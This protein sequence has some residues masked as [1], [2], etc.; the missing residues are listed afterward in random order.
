MVTVN[1]VKALVD[2]KDYEK[3]YQKYFTGSYMTGRFLKSYC[4]IGNYDGLQDII[5]NCI[6]K[7]HNSASVLKCITHINKI[8]EEVLIDKHK[9]LTML[10]FVYGQE[11]KNNK[12]V[13]KRWRR[14]RRNA[15]GGMRKTQNAQTVE[16]NKVLKI[17]TTDV[18]K[19]I[20]NDM[21][22]ILSDTMKNSNV[23]KVYKGINV[24][25]KLLWHIN[26]IGLKI[27]K[28]DKYVLRNEDKESFLEHVKNMNT[29]KKQISFIVKS[30]N[31]QLF[32]DYLNALKHNKKELKKIKDQLIDLKNILFLEELGNHINV[33]LNDVKNLIKG[34][35]QKGRK[36]SRK[37]YY[38]RYGKKH[39]FTY[40]NVYDICSFIKKK[41][42]NIEFKVIKNLLNGTGGWRITPEQAEIYYKTLL[43][44]DNSEYFDNKNNYKFRNTLR[45]LIENDNVELLK[46]LIERKILSIQYLHNNPRLM[47]YAIEHNAEDTIDMFQNLN[48]RCCSSIIKKI[49]YLPKTNQLKIFKLVEKI[50]YPID[51]SVLDEILMGGAIDV[52][53]YIMNKYDLKPSRKCAR[54]LCCNDSAMLKYSKFFPNVNDKNF[55]LSLI[56]S[57]W[58]RKRISDEKI[59]KLIKKNGTDVNKVFN[60]A[61]K[62][63]NTRLINLLIKKHDITDP[64][65]LVNYV[66]STSRRYANKN[67]V[68]IVDKLFSLD[69]SADHIDSI[70]SLFPNII[71]M[72]I[73]YIDDV[74]YNGNYYKSPEKDPDDKYYFPTNSYK[75]AYDF[76]NNLINFSTKINAKDEYLEEIISK[77]LGHMSDDLREFESSMDGKLIKSDIKNNKFYNNVYKE[78]EENDSVKNDLNSIICSHSSFG[79]HVL[80]NNYNEID[81]KLE[82]MKV[83]MNQYMCNFVSS[84]CD[85]YSYNDKKECNILE[86]FT[87]KGCYP[88]PYTW[89]IVFTIINNRLKWIVNDRYY[90]DESYSFVSFEWI[91]NALKKYNKVFLQDY[92]MI[93]D[94]IQ[95]TISMKFDEKSLNTTDINGED[96]LN[97]GELNQCL[98]DR[99]FNNARWDDDYDSIDSVEEKDEFD[100]LVEE[101]EEKEKKGKIVK[102]VKNK[103]YD[104]DN[105]S[106]D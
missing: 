85:D 65:L 4:R 66:K 91:V 62:V 41:N 56:Q 88:S 74:K 48:V 90:C 3:I 99:Y 93:I 78:I 83:L 19:F 45:K 86:V 43:L 6:V 24:T 61:T 14:R 96:V 68:E 53:D 42:L 64:N 72:Y 22:S 26:D 89:R 71:S 92:H 52:G 69:L 57:E 80:L 95:N 32:K 58:T 73:R 29:T 63:Y 5:I 104:S 2:S 28:T 11:I 39:S 38:S 77:L 60:K 44:L 20:E 55:P 37:R 17:N 13:K 67:D 51:K 101:I 100:I 54:A 79:I 50:G 36:K 33:T 98:F 35:R 84:L 70:K 15:M 75:Y 31:I 76:F 25:P 97:S 30:K 103:D 1:D 47:N 81:F 16:S 40:E 49:T 34:K 94:N 27:I 105:D 12:P 21:T 7:T 10:F 82:T 18:K 59:I 8:S 9:I 46:Q 102:V 87:S 23:E 106:S